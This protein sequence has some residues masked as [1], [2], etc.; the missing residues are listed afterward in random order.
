[1]D[2]NKDGKITDDDRT[3]FGN[4]NP[5]FTLGLNLSVNYKAFDF[6]TVIY[7]SFGNDVLNETRYFQDF[8]PQFQNSKSIPLLT[9][10]WVPADR[11]KPRDQWTAVN[12]NVKYPIVENGSYFSTNGVI[13]DFY[14]EDGSYVR[15]KQL[16]IGYTLSPA[17]LKRYGIDKARIYLQGANLFTITKY[18]GLDPEVAG[19]SVSFGVDYGVYPPSKT[20]N[21][22]VSLTF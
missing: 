8:Y 18:S 21:V 13:N 16:S 10:S 15:V 5:D 4:P 12:Q 22:G 19:S 3:F 20:F 11:S 14:K 7:G 1:V 9:S 6:S 2:V 17:T